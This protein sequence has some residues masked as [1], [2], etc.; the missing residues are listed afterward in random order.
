MIAV[1]ALL[2]LVM[3]SDIATRVRCLEVLR[4]SGP[5]GFKLSLRMIHINRLMMASSDMY[6]AMRTVSEGKMNNKA[7]W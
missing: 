7:T 3:N 5:R 6:I 2:N 4:V 1:F